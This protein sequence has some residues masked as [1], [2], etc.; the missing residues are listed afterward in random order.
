MV[1]KC[2]CGSILIQ[3][4]FYNGKWHYVCLSCGRELIK[5]SNI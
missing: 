1:K 5:K 2:K 3:R 4:K